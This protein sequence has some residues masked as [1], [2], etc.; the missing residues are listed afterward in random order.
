[1]IDKSFFV[2]TEVHAREVELGDGAKHTLWFKQLPA[3][4][5]RRFSLA[6]SS[7]DE[8]VRIKSIA[9]LLCASLCNEDGSPA[10]TVAQAMTLTAPAMNA[11]FEQVLDVNGQGSKKKD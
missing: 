6:E 5:F 1:M 3:I 8:D 2:S 4:E 10:L 7:D 9:K 11:I